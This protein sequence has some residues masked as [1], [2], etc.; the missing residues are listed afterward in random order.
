MNKWD[1]FQ[2]YCDGKPSGCSVEVTTGQPLQFTGDTPEKIVKR[3]KTM[4]A[5]L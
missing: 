2:R 5:R 4:T 1:A 3:L